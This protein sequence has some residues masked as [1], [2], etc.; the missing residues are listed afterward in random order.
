MRVLIVEDDLDLANAVDHILQRDGYEV[1]VVHDGENGIAY[2]ESGMYDVII[3]DVMLPKVN[4]FEAV[5]SLRKK[6]IETPILMLTA[7]G[8]VPDKIE[9]LDS[10]A[11]SYMTKPFS[12]K[13]LMA[14]LRA[15]TRRHV[16]ASQ[17]EVSAGDLT[18]DLDS[19][20]LKCGSETVRLKNKEFMLAKLF[21]EN[22]GKL[23]SRGQLAQT[24]WPDDP[25]V[26]NNSI[27]AYISMLRKKLQFLGSKMSLQTERSMGYRFTEGGSKETTDA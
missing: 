19:H 16:P 5:D 15:L 3:F 11:D 13:E 21:M 14:R 24:A 8:A 23:L 6:G 27:E 20:D 1:D 17:Q 4:G 25:Q 2:A 9:G 22:P 12:P 18:L 10:G 26:E 7:R